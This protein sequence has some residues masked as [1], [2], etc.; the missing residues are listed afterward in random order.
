MMMA[1][2]AAHKAAGVAW[3]RGIAQPS[4]HHPRYAIRPCLEV[5]IVALGTRGV[6]EVVRLDEVGVHEAL[7]R[8][9]PNMGS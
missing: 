2:V 1:K 9:W 3:A 5:L 8:Q 6:S 7:S 4:F